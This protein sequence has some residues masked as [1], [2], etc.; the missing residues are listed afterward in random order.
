MSNNL[1]TTKKLSNRGLSP[2][3]FS[4]YN[5]PPLI[6]ID[7]SSQFENEYQIAI[8]DKGEE[9]LK[10]VGK[11]NIYDE[12]QS[13]TEGSSLENIISR[14][15]NGDDTAL[16]HRSNS[17]NDLGITDFTSVPKDVFQMQNI[18]EAAK[19]IFN[20]LPL[21]ERVKYDNNFNKFLKDEQVINEKFKEEKKSQKK[22]LKGNVNKD[23]NSNSVSD[24]RNNNDDKEVGGTK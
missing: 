17:L 2:R 23:D 15:K 7:C 24:L 9:Y 12:I 6:K 19:R 5:K 4:R 22:G 18:V 8:D 11:V 3:F 21:D 13:H 1:K 10:V 20:S 16:N 14:F